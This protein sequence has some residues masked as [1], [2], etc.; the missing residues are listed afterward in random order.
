V[1]VES[2]SKDLGLASRARV[3]IH[4]DSLPQDVPALSDP[5]LI[6]AGSGVP[7]TLEAAAR[8]ALPG[9][10]IRTGERFGVAWELTGLAPDPQVVAYS[11]TVEKMDR[12][13]LERAGSLIGLFGGGPDLE[14]TWTEE[15]G[16]RTRRHFRATNLDLPHLEP[17]RYR[18]TLE[19]TLRGRATMVSERTLTVVE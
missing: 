14:L 12:G 11:L 10:T 2:W 1:S 15:D 6:D 4:V 9:T 3:G 19:A 7:G 8:Q 5:L 17:G 18:L 13:L 16:G